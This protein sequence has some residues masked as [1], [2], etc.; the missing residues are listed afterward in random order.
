GP[1][2][3]EHPGPMPAVA[4]RPRA[5]T[6][7]T[8][9]TRPPEAVLGSTWLLLTLAKDP[10]VPFQPMARLPVS[11]SV[12]GEANR[13][14]PG[15]PKHPPTPRGCQGDRGRGPERPPLTRQVRG[16]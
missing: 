6:A 13:F 14:A 4:T 15:P 7:A 3:G 2:Q 11:P 12:P 5:A 8:T 9:R 1:L 10:N 16:P